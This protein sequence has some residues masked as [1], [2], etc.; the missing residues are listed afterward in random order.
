MQHFRLA[1]IALSA[2]L[3]AACSG[4][5]KPAA[6]AAT[7]TAA[8]PAAVDSKALKSLFGSWGLDPANCGGEVLK[9]SAEAFEGPGSSCKVA[10]YTDNG[11]GTFTAAMSCGA[12]EEK[13]SLRPIF[14]PSGEG[15]D[16]VYLDRQNLRSE[17]LRCGPA[18]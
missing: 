5:D 1:A 12:A 15:I 3:L 18:S 8:A 7:K 17:V 11:D 10:G 4:G 16:L 14:A 9:I 6:D 13:V 2:L